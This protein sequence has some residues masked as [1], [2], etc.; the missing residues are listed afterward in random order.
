[1]G[2]RTTPPI[3][4]DILARGSR[5]ESRGWLTGLG[6]GDRWSEPFR[7]AFVGRTSTEDRQDP[8]LSLPRQLNNCR[9][10]LPDQAIIVAHYYDIESGRKALNARGRGRGHE[11][12]A[13]PVPREGGIQ[14]LLEDVA[15]PERRF[16]VVVCESIERIARRTYVGT[17]IENKLEEAGVPLLAADEPFNLNGKPGP[18]R[19]QVL[20]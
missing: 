7:V 6:Q 4:L 2:A 13:I 3:P 18:M 12:F 20:R 14:E 1:M 15:S 10:A 9:A 19:S 17:L 8:T 11:R 16:D 5:R